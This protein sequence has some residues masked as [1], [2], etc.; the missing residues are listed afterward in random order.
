MLVANALQAE[1]PLG[2]IRK[3]RTDDGERA[4]TLDLKSH[5][6]RIFVDAARAFALGLG[7]TETNTS[8]RLRLAGRRLGIDDREMGS[9]V[10]G[11]HFLQLLRLRAQ[12]GELQAEPRGADGAAPDKPHSAVNRIDPYALN[13]L[14]QRMLKESF[15]QARALQ[16]QL[17]R[18]F[19]Q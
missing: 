5:G 16:T 6:T 4:G 17:E 9:A 19:G 13:D 3:F 14:D 12:R 18:A 7:I 10:E 11:Y 2:R 15:R 1:P 8:Q